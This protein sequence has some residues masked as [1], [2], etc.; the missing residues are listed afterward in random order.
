MSRSRAALSAEPLAHFVDE[1]L[2]YLHETYPTEAAFDG[3]HVHDDLL[4]EFSRPA[5]D[6]QARELGGR[7]RRLDK[8][9]GGALTAEERLDRQ[10][11][12]GSI[13]ARI[14][15][16]EEVRRWQFDPRHYADTLG[17]SL[18]AQVFFQY[19][20]LPERARRVVSKLRQVPRLLEAARA[21]VTEPPG[22]FARAGVDA[23]DG[24]LDFIEHELPL[25]FR[26]LDDMHLLGDLADASDVAIRALRAYITHLRDVV[27]PRSRASFR[28]GP[29]RFGQ[30]LALNEGID[31]PV[32]QLLA[33][34]VREL[35]RTR[36][37]FEELA[38]ARGEQ[39]S[40][41]FEAVRRRQPADDDVHGTIQ[42]QVDELVAF[43]RRRK[44][45]SIPDH[46]PLLV[47]SP[48]RNAH[49]AYVWTLA[50]LWAPGAFETQVLPAHY[51]PTSAVPAWPADRQQ[52]KLGQLSDAILRVIAMREVLPGR[53]LQGEHRRR[54]TSPIRKTVFMLPVSLAEGWAHYGEQLLFDQ[55]YLR[56]DRGAKLG[57]L[58]AA[59]VRLAR[60]VV[61]IRLH[62][63]DLSVEQGMRFFREEALLGESAARR[64]S[65]RGTFDP[66]Y[67]LSALGKH[68][69][70]R[71]RAD[72]EA[73]DG[74]RFSLRQFHDDLLGAGALPFWAQRER[75]LGEAGLLLD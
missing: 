43:V 19:A 54:V 58:A 61:G 14:F 52:E 39:A 23:F 35:Q 22:L 28:L 9:D 13:R 45:A 24:V 25:A 3:V 2:A 21:N 48:A 73:R 56:G 8:I 15:A 17:R 71:L 6:Q 1:H 11:L 62:A 40:A 18:A 63:E 47:A 38:G 41:A 75:M 49:W 10:I 42:V 34:A 50:S 44:L 68:M 51:Y 7:L 29:D 20:P 70:L 27:A 30:L 59:L 36:A 69:L 74:N 37:E 5:V 67:V 46:G 31:T 60:T 4:E 66:A 26:Q 64:E 72:V 53:F 65:E 12:A 33:I 16:L 57:Q 55:G 32:G